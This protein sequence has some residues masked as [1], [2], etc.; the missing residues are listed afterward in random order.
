MSVRA[1][2]PNVGSD[3]RKGDKFEQFYRVSEDVYRAFL[4]VFE[5]QNPL[6]TDSEYARGKG[7]RDCVMHGNILGGFLS[8]FVGEVLPLDNVMIHSQEM[9]FAKPVYL[10]DRLR[11][12]VE[13]HD[14]FDSVNVV[15]LRFQFENADRVKVAKGKLHVGIL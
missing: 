8:H 12:S 13:V 5:D 11:L 6:H 1:T 9:N 15:E 10:G 2:V 3:M 14:V 7:F 4:G